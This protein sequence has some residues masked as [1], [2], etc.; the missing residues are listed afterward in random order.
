MLKQ[1]LY[2]LFAFFIIAS[3]SPMSEDDEKNIRDVFEEYR[4][5]LL[6][7]DG[8]AVVKC[9]DKK[10]IAYYDHLAELI[11]TADSVT[12]SSQTIL[13]KVCILS[14][15]HRAT[16]EQISSFDGRSLLEFVVTIELI[17]S[18]GAAKLDIG[19]ISVR[20]DSAR[21]Q[22]VHDGQGLTNSFLYYKENG[23]WKI[24]LISLFPSTEKTLSDAINGVEGKNV[25]DLVNT[26]VQEH[27][28]KPIVGS[29]WNP[30]K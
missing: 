25:D 9:V 11:R 2:L 21:G 23:R 20:G 1:S 12:V 27:S 3:C 15:R 16:K 4:L 24:D 28:K 5:S 19:N 8:K 26:L 7:K 17:D 13:D 18:A 10:T 6:D 14:A 29:L 22:I 30:V